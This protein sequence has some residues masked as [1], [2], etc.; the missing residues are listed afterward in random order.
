MEELCEAASLW[1]PTHAEGALAALAYARAELIWW[2]RH[3]KEV[4]RCIS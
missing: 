3:W 2:L 1:L 4:R